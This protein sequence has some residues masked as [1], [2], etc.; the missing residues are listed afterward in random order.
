MNPKRLLLIF[1]GFALLVFI[2]LVAARL[3]RLMEWATKGRAN[4]EIISIGAAMEEHRKHLGHYPSGE[5]AD[6]LRSLRGENEKKIVFL[7]MDA[8]S[9]GSGGEFLDPW[10]TPYRIEIQGTNHLRIASAGPNKT[11]GDGDDIQ[12]SSTNAPTKP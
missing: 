12:K 8:K 6:T 5:L 3:P 9:A 4:A 1:F 11:F 2:F 10:G 7:L